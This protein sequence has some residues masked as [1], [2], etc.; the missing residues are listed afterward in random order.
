MAAPRAT[1]PGSSVDVHA[2]SA[3]KGRRLHAS[4]NTQ[5]ESDD[6]E[7]RTFCPQFPSKDA[8]HR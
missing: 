8:P 6:G 2:L 7:S 3:P 5:T 1:N 4:A